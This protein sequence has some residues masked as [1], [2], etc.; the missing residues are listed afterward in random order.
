VKSLAIVA[1]HPVQY[2]AP[3]Y[4]ALAAITDLHVFFA[5]R[6]QPDEQ[7]RAGFGVA[8]EWDVPLLDGYPFEW[9]NNVALR[10]GVDHFNGCDTP[11]IAERIRRGRFDAVVV[12]GWQLRSY[13]QAIRAARRSGTPVMV[14]GDSQLSTARGSMRRTA[15]RVA[16]P[17]LLRSF[18]A[19]LTVGRRSEDYYRHYGVADHRMFRSPHCV[20][21]DFFAAAARAARESDAGI[22]G[23]AGFTDDDIVFVFVGKLIAKKRP[24]DFLDALARA[25]RTNR[26]IRGVVVGDGPLRGEVE[27]YQRDHDTG[28]VM[29]GFLNQQAIARAYVAADALVLPSDGGETWGLVVN[30]AMACGTPAIVSDAVGCV[31][32]LIEEGATG[33]SYACGDVAALADR[34]NRLAALT[35]DARLALGRHA[36]ER[37]ARYSPRVAALGVLDAMDH[38]H[39]L[40]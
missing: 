40:S 20:D 5:H 18:D 8:F 28:S 10:P 17:R 6:I 32:D 26:A 24:L 11:E 7:A 14:R 21:N 4:R 34:L 33:L 12:N 37:I 35:P 16:Y 13:W 15:M 27:A 30:E 25:R 23:E 36:L 31:P 9:L 38:V 19:F 3:W 39:T 29:I 1:S 22:R 2:Q